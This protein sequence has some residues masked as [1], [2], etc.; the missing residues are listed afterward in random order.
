MN[1]GIV[2]RGV[3]LGLVAVAAVGMMAST[4]RAHEDPSGCFETGPAIIVSVFRADGVTGV[5][6]NVSQCETINYRA[7]LQKA[8]DL[9]SICAFSGGTFRLT[10]PDGVVHD[11]D[12]NVPCIGGNTGLEGCLDAVDFEQSPLFPYTVNPADVVGGLITATAL[13]TGGVAHDSPLNTPG[14]AAT[15][16]K[17][18][19]VVSCND[20][21]LCTTDVCDPIAG[22][23]ACSDPPVVCTDNNVCTTDT[24][25]PANGQC[26]TR[27]TR[28]ATTT[29]LHDGRLRP[30]DG[31]AS[32][33]RTPPCND[34]NVC[35][36]DTCDP[37]TGCV[38]TTAHADLQRQQRS[39]RPTPAT[40]RRAACTRRRATLRR[41]QRCTTDSCD[42]ATGC[43][44]TDNTATCNDNNACTTRRLRPGDGLH[45]HAGRLDCDDN[46]VCTTD[47]CD[48]ATGCMHTDDTRP[49]TT[50][51]PAR[52]TP[53]T[54]RRAACTRR[55]RRRATTTTSARPTP[56]TRP[57]AACTRRQRRTATTT[58][59]ARPT[60]AT[61]RRAACT[62]RRA[63]CNDNNACTTDACNP[64]TGLR[65]TRRTRTATTTTSARRTPA[66]RRRAACVT[67]AR[68]TATTTTSCTTDT[69]DPVHGCAHTPPLSCNDDNACTDD[70]CNP[71]LGCQNV[72]NN[73][74]VCN[75]LDHFQCYEIKPFAFA[76]PDRDGRG[77]V[78]R[79]LG[80][81]P[82]AEPPVRAVRQAR[83]GS[84]RPGRSGAPGRLPRRS[85]A[86]SRVPN[87]EIAN[88]FG[89][90][91]LDL[92]RRSFLFV[93]TAKSLV[94]PAA[95][96]SPTRRPD[97]F[98][99][100]LVRRSTG[101][102]RFQQIRGVTARGSV[103][104]RSDG[105]PAARATSARRRTRTTRIRARVSH[106]QGL[107]CYKARHRVRFPDA[108]AVHQQPVRRSSR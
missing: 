35:T 76:S 84:D 26:V 15:T 73:N 96:R 32:S 2:G 66:T 5:V 23:A 93:P 104:C 80:E 60:P 45:A 7:T 33:R 103:R 68:S 70:S 69:C 30:G 54:R 98:Q 95:G 63:N 37:A 28:R 43:V 71:T 55:R 47:T 40:R 17:S 106:P 64:A 89:T 52:P 82:L 25:D 13:Y 42:P 97:H 6:G 48:P 16:P 41:Q 29:T 9:D 88:Q 100:Y 20:N 39:A 77:S 74:P 62:R 105:P 94:G 61:R 92:I 83:R 86:R 91:K 46:N 19:P 14:V 4:A 78:R 12:L 72:P 38:I 107:L 34:N 1:R 67:A 24:C 51:T 99:C 79:Q 44:H 102:P 101:E 49:A 10:T 57:P 53:A 3:R 58:T 22:S 87:Q 81:P 50:T 8:Q 75:G 56:A 85:A 31:P 27:R 36:T 18:T 21:N 65:R 59:P 90:L 11:I 108:R